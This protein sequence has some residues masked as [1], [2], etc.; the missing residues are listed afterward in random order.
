VPISRET[1]AESGVSRITPPTGRALSPRLGPVYLVYTAWK[2]GREGIWK[3]AHGAATE[4]WSD[5]QARVVG[6][7]ARMPEL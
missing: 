4:L 3:L 2:G 6:A 7:P 5:S 1:I